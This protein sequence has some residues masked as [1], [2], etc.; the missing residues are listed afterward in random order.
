MTDSQALEGLPG[1][2]PTTGAATPK[3]AAPKGKKA[4]IKG[5]R[6]KLDDKRTVAVAKPR[7]GGGYLIELTTGDVSFGFRVSH[8]AFRAMVE[9]AEAVE[10]DWTKPAKQV[11]RYLLTLKDG[12]GK[13]TQAGEEVVE[14]QP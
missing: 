11:W 4:P 7:E 3:S 10:G 8:E 6:R 14:P 1:P 12:E 2:R 5:L 13:W 9:L